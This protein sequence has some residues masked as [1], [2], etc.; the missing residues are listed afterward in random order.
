MPRLPRSF[1]FFSLLIFPSVNNINDIIS[2]LSTPRPT[3]IQH[4]SL[5]F[6]LK[7]SLS[8]ALFEIYPIQIA[9]CYFRCQIPLPDCRLTIPVPP[10]SSIPMGQRGQNSHCVLFNGCGCTFKMTGIFSHWMPIDRVI[11]FGGST[12]YR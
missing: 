7:L 12:F 2:L 8:L 5:G 10:R 6:F 3:F 1:V 4:L 9:S 11:P